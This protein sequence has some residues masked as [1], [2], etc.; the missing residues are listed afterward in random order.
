M[1]F[2][3]KLIVTLIVLLIGSSIAISP[4]IAYTTATEVQFTVTEK[5]RVVTKNTSKYIIFTEK[6]VFE[7]TDSVWYLKFNSSDIYGKLNKGETYKAK[8]YGFRVPF[9]SW[10]RNIVSIT[11]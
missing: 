6:E 3:E 2:I 7:N 9:L 4:I 5:E 1:T 11:K 8:V 10:Y